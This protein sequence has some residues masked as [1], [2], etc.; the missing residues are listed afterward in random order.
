MAEP[1]P[2]SAAL[3]VQFVLII[4]SYSICEDLDFVLKLFTV[5]RRLFGD[6]E[7]QTNQE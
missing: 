2:L 6:V 3:S 5:E 7:R 1:V 4:V